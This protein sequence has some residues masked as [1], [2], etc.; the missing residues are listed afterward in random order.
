M[1]DITGNVAAD[2]QA[3]LGTSAHDI[4]QFVLATVNDAAKLTQA[5]QIH[6]VQSWAA[7]IGH[8]SAI[9]FD[10]DIEIAMLQMGDEAEAKDDFFDELMPGPF[11]DDTP[12]DTP[13]L[14]D[15][16][17]EDDV[18]WWCRYGWQ[19]HSRQH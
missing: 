14:H 16:H 7:W 15:D 2:A 11:D 6:L 12:P 13:Q 3:A 10:D 5:I 8:T 19:R 18:F 4:D 17:D 9:G 1:H